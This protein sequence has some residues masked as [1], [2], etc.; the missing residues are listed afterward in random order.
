[1]AGLLDAATGVLIDGKWRSGGAIAPVRD[2]FTQLPAAEVRLGSESDAHDAVTS[3]VAAARRPLPPAQRHQ[4]LS[5]AARLLAANAA[6][7]TATA[8]SKTA[9]TAL[10]APSTRCRK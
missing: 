3:A 6:E 4:I 9:A 1:M 2:K 5:E 7:V 10:R 8:E